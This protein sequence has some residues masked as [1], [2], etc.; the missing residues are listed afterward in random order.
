MKAKDCQ[1][2]L[3]CNWCDKYDRQ[4]EHIEFLIAKENYEEMM[5]KQREQEK[6]ECD[7]DYRYV[8]QI[9]GSKSVY[10]LYICCK[11]GAE[12]MHKVIKDEKGVFHET[13]CS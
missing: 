9:C 6:C 4:C 8:G 13:I 10:R 1:Y 2:R 7:H 11:C 5:N 3:P 12:E